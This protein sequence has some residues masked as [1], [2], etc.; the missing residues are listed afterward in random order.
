MNEDLEIMI[1][2]ISD[3]F[4]RLG[5]HLALSPITAKLCRPAD[6]G[7]RLRR[8]GSASTRLSDPNPPLEPQSN[9]IN[10]QS[11]AKVK[12]TANT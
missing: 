6:P 8:R 1:D 11:H 7:E 9:K 5:P 4:V 3:I 10:I 12:H 2:I